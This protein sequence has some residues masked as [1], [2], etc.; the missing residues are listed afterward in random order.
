VGRDLVEDLI[1]E[2][3][4]L[5]E[6]LAALEAAIADRVGG[7]AA[8]PAEGMADAGQALIA[9]LTRHARREEDVLFGLLVHR[10]VPLAVLHRWLE[11][12]D[13]IEGVGEDVVGSLAKADGSA[14]LRAVRALRKSFSA[15]AAE[16]EAVVFGLARRVITPAD[17]AE[18][19]QDETAASGPALPDWGASFPSDPDTVE[20]LRHGDGGG[21]EV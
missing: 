17:L 11:E 13:L 19:A 6:R 4:R 20:R 5:R 1:R 9:Q 8:W 2:H 14:A 7:G 15:H 18:R 21:C 16:E 10:G 3:H 12:H